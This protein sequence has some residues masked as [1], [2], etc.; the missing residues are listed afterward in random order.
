LAACHFRKVLAVSRIL[1]AMIIVLATLIFFASF[2]EIVAAAPFGY[3]DEWGFH[4]GMEA[5]PPEFANFY[6]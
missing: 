3:E 6:A 1:I 4:F 2:F 5:L